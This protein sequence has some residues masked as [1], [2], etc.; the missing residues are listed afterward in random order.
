MMSDATTR[1]SGGGGGSSSGTVAAAPA[2]PSDKLAG[3][4]SLAVPRRGMRDAKITFT[5]PTHVTIEAG[6]NLSGDYVVQGSYLLIL[7]RDEGLRPLAW[8]INSPD[9]LTVV[10]SPATGDFTGA[11]LVRAA[12]T[13]SADTEDDEANAGGDFVDE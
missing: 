9:S 8:R 6:E 4:F 5:D 12:A 3:A 11:T 2:V 7:T 10:R 13:A 1:P